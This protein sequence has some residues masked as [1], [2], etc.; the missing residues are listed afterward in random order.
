MALVPGAIAGTRIKELELGSQGQAGTRTSDSF[1]IYMP[2]S[3]GNRQLETLIWFSYPFPQFL[4][5]LSRKKKKGGRKKCH[6]F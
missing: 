5:S 4:R 1:N 2:T 6:F 3:L